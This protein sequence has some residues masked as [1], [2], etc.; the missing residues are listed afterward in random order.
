MIR[1]FNSDKAYGR[2]IRQ[3]LAGDV[4]WPDD[5]DQHRRDRLHCGRAWDFAAHST[6]Q[7]DSFNRKMARL[8]DRDDMVAA[9]ISTFASAT[10]HCARCHDHKFDPVTQ[11]DYYSPASGVFGIERIARPFD[12]D[13]DVSRKRRALRETLRRIAIEARDIRARRAMGQALPLRTFRRK[14]TS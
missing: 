7:E 3:Q 12:A 11:E 9:T 6:L 8:L 4:L 14:S 5:P 1:S 2:F 10:V 13:P